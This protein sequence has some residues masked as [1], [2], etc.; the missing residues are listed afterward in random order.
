MHVCNYVMEWRNLISRKLY[1]LDI[2]RNDDYRNRKMNFSHDIMQCK[3]KTVLQRIECQ[4]ISGFTFT[5][6]LATVI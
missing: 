4:L 2:P 1:Y 3:D 6:Q 5:K